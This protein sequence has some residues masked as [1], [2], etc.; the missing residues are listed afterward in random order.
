MYLDLKH[1]VEEDFWTSND[2]PLVIVTNYI[3]VH[4]ELLELSDTSF[5][6]SFSFWMS[7][8]ISFIEVS[9]VV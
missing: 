3:H 1:S 5:F 6:L 2:E 9:L 7:L 8:I 4:D